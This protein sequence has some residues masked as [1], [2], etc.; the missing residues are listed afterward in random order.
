[1]AEKDRNPKAS[2]PQSRSSR[3]SSSP[4]PMIFCNS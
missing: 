2:S 1:M 3:R 4:S